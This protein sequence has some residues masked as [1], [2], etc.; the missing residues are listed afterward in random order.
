MQLKKNHIN[1]IRIYKEI[2]G[3]HK[4][5]FIFIFLPLIIQFQGYTKDSYCS[6]HNSISINYALCSALFQGFKDAVKN[7]TQESLIVYS[8]MQDAD[9]AARLADIYIAHIFNLSP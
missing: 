3:K 8:F 2:A 1:N 5:M 7:T 4:K 6:F 9:L